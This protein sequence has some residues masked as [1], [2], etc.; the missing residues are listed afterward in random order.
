MKHRP[1]VRALKLAAKGRERLAFELRQPVKVILFGSQARG[2]AKKYS[3]IDLF[4]IVTSLDDKT[5][6]TISEITWEIGFEAEKIISAIPVTEEKIKK[7]YFLPLYKN[8]KKEGVV[9]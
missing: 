2:D 6:R 9:V 8:I 3:D 5:R 1:R 4:I 7:Y